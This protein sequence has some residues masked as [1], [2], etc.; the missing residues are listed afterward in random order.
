MKTLKAKK[1]TTEQFEKEFI[2]LAVLSEKPPEFPQEYFDEQKQLEK[3]KSDKRVSLV[4]VND[5][6]LMEVVRSEIERAKNRYKRELEE[7]EELSNV[8]DIKEI[9]YHLIYGIIP[10]FEIEFDLENVELDEDDDNLGVQTIGDFNYIGIIA[11]GDWENPVF[12]IL[13]IDET[14]KIAGYVPEDGNIYNKKLKS[15]FGNNHE[16]ED[17][18]FGEDRKMSKKRIE[19]NDEDAAKEQYGV[20]EDE[21]QNIEFDFD[22]MK[23]EIK[24]KIEVVG[25]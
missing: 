16:R 5:E 9:V 3:I 22:K 24:N 12:F 17:Y 19:Y 2:K 25:E 21:I 13:F 8:K 15:A 18:I 11:G 7:Y 4:G 1:M 20:T 23:K 10:E 6:K 14:G